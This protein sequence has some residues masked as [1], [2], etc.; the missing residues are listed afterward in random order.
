MPCFIGMHD[1]LRAKILT[2]RLI[3]FDHRR[4]HL[5]LRLTD[6]TEAELQMVVLCEQ[7][8][9]LRVLMWNSP[10][11]VAIMASSLGPI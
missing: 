5:P 2:N 10:L 6:R 8:L 7:A 1:I 3:G 4:V 11:S 9:D